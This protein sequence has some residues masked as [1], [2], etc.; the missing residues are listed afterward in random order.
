MKISLLLA[1]S[2]LLSFLMAKIFRVVLPVTKLIHN[3][4]FWLL[5]AFTNFTSRFFL[6][7]ILAPVHNFEIIWQKKKLIVANARLTDFYH[8]ATHQPFNFYSSKQIHCP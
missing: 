6:W 5:M 1:P 3:M 8:I 2:G 4:S 7:C